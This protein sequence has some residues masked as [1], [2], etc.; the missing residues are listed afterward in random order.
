[1]KEVSHLVENK[2]GKLWLVLEQ[3]LK[4]C[5]FTL[6]VKLGESEVFEQKG[7]ANQNGEVP[8]AKW[9]IKHFPSPKE[10][11]NWKIPLIN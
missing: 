9:T 5:T 3:V 1:M 11:K 4:Y 8:K 6:I 7:A 10:S 2:L